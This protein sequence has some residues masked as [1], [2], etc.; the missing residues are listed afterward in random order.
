MSVNAYAAKRALF[1]LLASS[2]LLAGVQVAYAYPARDIARV[3]VYGGGV[4]LTQTAASAEPGTLRLETTIVNVYV[5]V[6]Q[7][8]SDVRAADV[9]AETVA[10]AVL[11]VIS[12]GSALTGALSVSGPTAGLGDYAQNV[13]SAVSTLGLQVQVDAY[14]PG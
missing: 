10:N 2:P 4:R 7:E 6:E 11:S 9:E 13:D 12:A 14:V 5:R 8:D 3:C 1:D